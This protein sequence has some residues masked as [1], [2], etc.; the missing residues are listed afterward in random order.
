MTALTIMEADRRGFLAGAALFALATG[1]SLSLSACS[2]AAEN[3]RHQKL[4]DLVSALV[5]PRTDTAGAAET[6]VGT[7]VML[8]LA[9]GLEDSRKPLPED[10]PS[11]LKA[12]QRADGSL[13]QMAWLANELDQRGGGDVLKL[14][15][16]RQQALLTEIDVEAYAEGV[17]EHPWRT[18]KALILVGYYTSMAGGSQ[19]LR[20][21]HVPGRW[22]SDVPLKPGDRAFSS[23]WT[24]VEF[25]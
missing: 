4:A 3:P 8:G 20:Y 2:D 6:G 22:D 16:A 18:I 13:N 1:L 25:G 23:D 12:R 21:E 17:R 10:A 14:E 19:E 24:A 15:P 11:S 5:I 7:F 9:H